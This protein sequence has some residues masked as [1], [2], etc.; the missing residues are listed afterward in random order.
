VYGGYGLKN[1]EY[2]FAVSSSPVVLAYCQSTKK[3]GAA[4][5]VTR[6]GSQLGTAATACGSAA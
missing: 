1:A 5:W 3:R 2:A 6:V 4:A